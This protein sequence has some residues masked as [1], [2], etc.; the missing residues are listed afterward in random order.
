MSK[1]SEKKMFHY[2]FPRRVG[3]SQHAMLGT[4]DLPEVAKIIE[5]CMAH[6]EANLLAIPGESNFSGLKPNL[7]CR[8]TF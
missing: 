5:G 2:L 4:M 6:N 7:A 3:C 8:S 1:S